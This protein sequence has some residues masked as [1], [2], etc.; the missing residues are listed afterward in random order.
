MGSTGRCETHVSGGTPSNVLIVWSII[1]MSRVL[2]RG[3]SSTWCKWLR[4]GASLVTSNIKWR[5]IDETTVK[6]VREQAR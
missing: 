4:V 2:P 5:T 1:S 3:D 6:R